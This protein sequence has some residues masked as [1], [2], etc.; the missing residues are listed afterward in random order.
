MDNLK[1]ENRPDMHNKILG[2]KG[3]RAARRFLKRNGYKILE[4]NFKSPFGE[5]DVIAQKGEVIAFIEVKTRI[6][7]SF[8][9]PSQAVTPERQKR[10][11]NAA[12][13]YFAERQI[14]FV[15][16]FDI[17]EVFRGEINHIENAFYPKSVF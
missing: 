13:Y 16:R 7:D 15:V 3:E 5:V 4:K 8:G 1:G 17:I 2:A 12:R 11:F 14:D 9:S 10:Y 6:S